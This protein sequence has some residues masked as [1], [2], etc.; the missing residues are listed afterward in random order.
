MTARLP[1]YFVAVTEDVSTRSIWQM[2]LNGI[3]ITLGSAKWL[4][5]AQFLLLQF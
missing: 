3:D 4:V 5:L 2:T 1:E